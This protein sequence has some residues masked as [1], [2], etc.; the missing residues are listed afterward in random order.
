MEIDKLK[1]E[2]A[3]LC[4]KTG[5]VEE[6]LLTLEFHQRCKNLWFSGII[7]SNHGSYYDYNRKVIDA[8]IQIPTVNVNTRLCPYFKDKPHDIIINFSWYGDVAEA[9]K[10]ENLL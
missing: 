2:D 6:K 4:S 10:H 3:D 9:L 7:E 8:I 1:K 5:S